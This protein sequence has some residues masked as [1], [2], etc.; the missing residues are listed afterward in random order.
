M[1]TIHRVSADIKNSVWA[2]P[3]DIL[4]VMDRG[5]IKELS[6]CMGNVQQQM[7]ALG[8]ARS[9]SQ[10]MIKAHELNNQYNTR[11]R[12]LNYILTHN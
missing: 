2:R 4:K 8:H 10:I 11:H 3:Y 7:M 5:P 6:L 1:A 12:S 9:H